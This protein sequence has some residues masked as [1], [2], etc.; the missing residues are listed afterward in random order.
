MR[1][2]RSVRLSLKALFAHKVRTS[3]ALAAVCIGVAA[4]VLTSAVGGGAERDIRRRIESMG[5]NLLVVRPAVVP[6]TVGRP[7]FRGTVTTLRLDD[8][9]ALAELPRVALAAPGSEGGAVVK[10]GAAAT[11]TTIRGTTANYLA[12]RRFTL[13]SGRF[14]D[15]DD[16]RAA[17]RVAVLGARVADAL[18]E[19]GPV[20]QQIRI[21]GVPYDVIGVLAAKGA[22]A[23][24]DQDSQVLI[25]VRTA[26][27]RVFNVSWLNVIFVSVADPAGIAAAEREIEA[28]LRQRHRVGA[29]GELDAE[30]QNT[31]R[32]FRMQQQAAATLTRLS[33]GL[34]AIALVVGGTGIMGLMLL[35]VKERTGEIGL[36][37]AV[38]ARPRDVLAQFLIEATVLSVGGWA[39]GVAL[40]ALGALVVTWQTDWGVTVPTLAV[41]A[42]LA[43]AVIIGVGFGAV[44]ARRASLVP[45]LRALVS[46]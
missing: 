39:I 14:I 22:L 21:R 34:A 3:L 33:A 13:T 8:Y 44:P 10:A 16:D 4:V 32:F 1:L 42:S 35:S 41:L 46:R 12:I 40:A 29:D 11:P 15:A 9:Q 17:R 20:G 6:R 38:G 28:L 27:R 5:V 18:F 19:D 2:G 23:D 30:V 37:M 36:R 45:P 31:E 7:E 24:G 25:P 43:M 26:M